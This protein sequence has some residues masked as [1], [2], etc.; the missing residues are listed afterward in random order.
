MIATL[1]LGVLLILCLIL[2][3][4]VSHLRIPK[5]T[6]YLLAGILISPSALSLFSDG[7]G[8]SIV[9]VL[10]DLRFVSDLALGLI[11]FSIGGEFQHER[12]KK[13]GKTVLTISLCETAITFSLVFCLLFFFTHNLPVAIC[14]AVLAIATAPAATLLVLREY[15]SEGVVTNSLLILTGLN[16]F[17]CL[18]VFSLCLPLIISPLPGVAATPVSVVFLVSLGRVFVSL[19]LGCML[20]FLLSL[21]EKNITKPVERILMTLAVIVLGIGLAQMVKVSPL[22]VNLMVG[23][24]VINLAKKGNILFEELEKIDLPIYAAFFALSGANLHWELLSVVG[25]VGILYCA[26]RIAGKLLGVFYGAVKVRAHD[27]LKRYGGCGLLAQAGVALGLALMVQDRDPSLGEIISTTILSAVILFEV[28]GPIAV[29]WAVVKS[30]EVKVINLLHRDEGAPFRESLR[31]MGIHL[32]NA[33]GIPVWRSE[34]FT[35]EILVEHIMRSHIEVIHEETHFDQI[36]KVIE[37]SRYN[38]FPVVDANETFVGMISFQDVRDVLYDG[39][40]KDLV[41]AKDI[42]NPT[43][44]CIHSKPTIQEALDM[45]QYE[46]IDMLPVIDDTTAKHLLGI[47]TQRDVLAVFKEKKE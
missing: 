44:P 18:T 40:M 2:G 43:G 41:I 24:T 11:A 5:V 32:R 47:V 30:G 37:H 23:V 25:G 35:G 1:Y 3:R 26:G 38:L 8:K 20:G 4:L 9:D 39:I 21:F 27:N 29:R 7:L 10:A 13:M 46:K 28:M 12:F 19:L 34:R 42:V 14:L 16:N 17:I 45:F 15:D 31:E 33:L 22:L 36:L 6:G